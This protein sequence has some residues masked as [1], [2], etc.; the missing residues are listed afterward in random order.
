M[1][2]YILF[3]I[4]VLFVFWGCNRSSS[5]TTT[6][7]SDPTITSMHFS[8]HVDYPHMSDA[9]FTIVNKFSGDTGLIYNADS[10][11]YG[12]KLNAAVPVFGYSATPYALQFHVTNDTVDTFF[13]FKTGDSVNFTRQPIYLTVTSQDRSAK[14]TYRIKPVVHTADPELFKWQQMNTAVMP[15]GVNRQNVL[16]FGD[17]YYYL[18]TDGERK[19]MFESQDLISWHEKDDV[20]TNDIEDYISAEDCI[21]RLDNDKVMFS[22]DWKSWLP[23]FDN[24]PVQYTFDVILFWYDDMLWTLV[25]D[26]N[27]KRSLA[28]VEKDD[29]TI[30]DEIPDNFPV[31]GFGVVTFNSVSGRKRAMLVGGYNAEGKMLNSRWNIELTAQGYQLVNFS[32]DS[33]NPFKPIAGVALAYYDSK[34]YAFG[35]INESND[36]ISDFIRVSGDEGM[37]WAV[38]DTAHNKMPADFALRYNMSVLTTSHGEVLLFGGRSKQMLYSDVYRGVLNQV[39]WLL[40]E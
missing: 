19:V 1:K 26:Q 31:E 34:I 14:K 24:M 15:F 29:I 35:G 5:K 6:L 16:A 28:I 39:S 20:L 25:S 9:K 8:K 10:I 32:D 7:S 30:L 18:A 23:F 12:T 27:G 36:L 11:A 3:F 4:A 22:T 40:G 33:R 37:S 2:R 13:Y 17:T 38:A 21:L